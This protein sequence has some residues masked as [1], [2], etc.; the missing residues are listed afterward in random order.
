M[1]NVLLNIPV[2]AFQSLSDSEKYLLDYIGEN[3]D[4]IPGLS[5][6]KLSEYS[7]VSTATIVRLMKKIGYNGYSSFKFAVKEQLDSSVHT[8]SLEEIDKDIRQAI[9]K[10]ELEVIHTI[11]LLNTQT[12]EKAVQA[13]YNAQKIYLFSRGFSERIAKDMSIKLQLLGKYSELHTAPSLI[14]G[15]SKKLKKSDLAI[16]ISLGGETPELVEACKNCSIN[17]VNTITITTN[18]ESPLAKMS[19]ITLNGYKSPV[20]LLQE[21]D[22]SSRLP[23]EVISRILLDAYIIRTNPRL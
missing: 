8:D 9:K 19:V 7:T 16:F 10:N 17:Q 20:S 4:A 6:V 18:A 15:I 12:L 5:I 21:F 22:V 14:K 11:S 13:I 2:E 1:N 23:L 3:L